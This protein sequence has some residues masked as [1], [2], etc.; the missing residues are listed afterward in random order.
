MPVQGRIAV[1]GWIHNA[2]SRRD[3]MKAHVVALLVTLCIAASASAAPKWHDDDDDGRR[4]RA[5]G[6]DRDD[7]N[8]AHGNGNAY[9][10]WK[11]DRDDRAR[12]PIWKGPRPDV[13]AV[14][15]PT[16]ALL[17]GAGVALVALQLRRRRR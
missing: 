2:R 13:V 4:G 11:R 8:G 10:H 5:I 1:L 3:T 16:G 6:L 7:S 12:D 15:E 17:F 14:P 9:G